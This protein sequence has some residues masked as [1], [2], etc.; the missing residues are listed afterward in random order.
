VEQLNQVVLVAQGVIRGRLTPV[1]GVAAQEQVIR[2]WEETQPFGVA[3]E[4][5]VHQV[6]QVDRA[7]QE[8]LSSGLLKAV[9]CM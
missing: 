4:V 9:Q 3:V 7:I 1:M 8:L 2:E 5:Q 6:L